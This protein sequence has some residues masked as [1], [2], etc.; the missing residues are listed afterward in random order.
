MISGIIGLA[1]A[2][3]ALIILVKGVI[4]VPAQSAVI[5]ERFGEYRETLRAGLNFIVPFV[6]RVAYRRSLKENVIDVPAQTCITSDNVSIAIDGVLYMQVVDPQKSAYGISDYVVGVVQLAQTSLRSAIGKMALDKTFES[7]DL[8]NKQ[9][10]SDLNA[11]T[12]AWGVK[13]LRYEIRDLTPPASIMQ[14]ME[15]Q[16]KAER[17]K[18]AAILQSEGEKQSKINLAE[19]ERASAI[20]RSE[21]E[22]QSMINRAEGQA[23]QILQVAK[24]T[25][26]GLASVKAQ[27]D[28]DA[29]AAAQL[30][31]AEQYIAKFGELAKAGN[32]LIIPANAADTGAML[33]TIMGMIKPGTGLSSPAGALR[34]SVDAKS[35]EAQK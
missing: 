28:N 7:R 24:A 33:G 5:I 3:L 8:I 31:L 18:R 16:V 4:I 10:C 30:K 32:T 26:D 19:G 9:V 1:F 6:D 35:V 34:N 14:A 23:A 11:A 13:V 27:L 21:G 17:E 22:K 20:A 29:M 25:A 2:C 12:V 15:R